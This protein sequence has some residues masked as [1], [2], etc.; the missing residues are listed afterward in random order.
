[1]TRTQLL[2]IIRSSYYHYTL[3]LI[4]KDC[5]TPHRQS[6]GCCSRLGSV[7]SEQHE[8]ARLVIQVFP[9]KQDL[10]VTSIRGIRVKLGSRCQ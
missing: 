5:V 6:C 3:T 9:W 7:T 10:R 2:N 4:A 1:M 8:R